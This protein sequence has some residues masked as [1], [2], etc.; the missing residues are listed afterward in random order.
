MDAGIDSGRCFMYD[1][2]RKSLTVWAILYGVAVCI[3]WSSWP[4]AS[5]LAIV[6]V[7]FAIDALAH[8]MAKRPG[9]PIGMRLLNR[10]FLFQRA[11]FWKLTGGR[12]GHRPQ[13]GEP[14]GFCPECGYALSPGRCPECGTHV[15]KEALS[16]RPGKR[17]PFTHRI[18]WICIVA[19]FAT[20]GLAM[21]HRMLPWPQL[22]PLSVLLYL[23]DWH[24]SRAAAELIS[25]VT[26]GSLTDEEERRVCARSLRPSIRLHPP[27]PSDGRIAVTV[28]PETALAPLLGNMWIYLRDIR[29]TKGGTPLELSPTDRMTTANQDHALFL[30]EP[31]GAGNHRLNVT[32]RMLVTPAKHSGN[33]DTAAFCKIPFSKWISLVVAQQDASTVYSAVTGDSVRSDIETNIA[34]VLAR[35]LV[36]ENRG[37]RRTAPYLLIQNGTRDAFPISGRVYVRRS[38]KEEY[39]FVD[40]TIVNSAEVQLID[41]SSIQ[42]ASRVRTLHV[43]I[44]PD[45]TIMSARRYAT[46]LN[47]IGEI[48]ERDSIPT[49]SLVVQ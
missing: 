6:P 7:A 17:A 19:V 2:F 28:I 41:L 13:D 35:R 34:I 8:R 25:R 29:I 40:Q 36:A 15:S 14:Q 27:F 46:R 26:N 32:G 18:A 12:R 48:I 39:R 4:A 42:W 30:V 5:Y 38:N 16:S 49:S 33:A 3:A 31:L 47:Y 10:L 20:A 45:P 24:D 9:P 23:H 21:A 22:A 44:E 43:R 1:S 37:E 11:F